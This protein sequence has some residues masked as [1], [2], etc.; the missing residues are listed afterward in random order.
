MFN[1]LM[2]QGPCILIFHWNPKVT[3][4]VWTESL[5]T[6]DLLQGSGLSFNW[7]F[8]ISPQPLSSQI[9]SLPETSLGRIPWIKI[10]SQ[11]LMWGFCSRKALFGSTAIVNLLVPQAISANL[12]L[13]ISFQA[14]VRW[15]YCFPKQQWSH[16]GSLYTPE[17]PS[18]P[19]NCRHISCS[20]NS[21]SFW[22]SI[23]WYCQDEWE[24]RGQ[25]F[26]FWPL[27]C[28]F[29]IECSSSLWKLQVLALCYFVLRFSAEAAQQKQRQKKCQYNTQPHHL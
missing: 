8:M 2:M 25:Q 29:W 1:M 20:S 7:Q 3:K 27:L 11:C 14:W 19:D 17:N 4:L 6:A 5:Q 24:A 21:L 22:T 18:S 28:R 12:S 16:L 26:S 15:F 10:P 13:E 23:L 9:I